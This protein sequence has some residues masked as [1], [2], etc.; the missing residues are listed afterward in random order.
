MVTDEKKRNHRHGD[1]SDMVTDEKKR[2]RLVDACCGGSTDMVTDEKKTQ[3]HTDKV[4]DQT[5]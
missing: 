4:T 2:N 3:T 1:R 5:W